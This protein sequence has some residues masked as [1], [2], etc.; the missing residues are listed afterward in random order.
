VSLVP[1][2]VGRGTNIAAHRIHSHWETEPEPPGGD[3]PCLFAE[4]TNAA[5]ALVTMTAGSG[6]GGEAYVKFVAGC[7]MSFQR[8]DSY[9][10][11][12]ALALGT[13]GCLFGARESAGYVHGFQLLVDWNFLAYEHWASDVYAAAHFDAENRHESG[14]VANVS[15]PSFRSPRDR[16]GDAVAIK[17]QAAFE[18]IRASLDDEEERLAAAA[19]DEAVRTLRSSR[20]PVP[21]VGV[22]ADG[23]ALAQWRGE[24]SGVLLVFTG[25]GT[26]TAS[27]K[28]DT[29]AR[30]IDDSAEYNVADDFPQSVL[31]AI[32]DVR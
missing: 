29:Q 9:G 22:N 1:L 7:C 27:V 28:R 18:K 12:A 10:N 19:I 4:I 17:F 13:G 14:V 31:G 16:T 23:A 24:T 21:W 8:S 30:Y 6:T 15:M 32:I 3:G 25:D 2:E 20:V 11:V 5:R 26:F